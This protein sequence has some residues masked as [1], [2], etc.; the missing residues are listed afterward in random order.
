M[1]LVFTFSAG[2]LST[3]T[4]ALRRSGNHN[5]PHADSRPLEL[6]VK[7]AQLVF[8]RFQSEAIEQ[9][10]EVIV[11]GMRL[12]GDVAQLLEVDDSLMVAGLYAVPYPRVEFHGPVIGT[13]V[14]RT[15]PHIQ[16][17]HHV[18]RSKNENSAGSKKLQL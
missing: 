3:K 6:V 8:L 10:Q 18:A 15:G 5:R 13:V 9:R 4:S 12:H 14:V 1:R 11:T 2:S 7:G 17:V 16:V